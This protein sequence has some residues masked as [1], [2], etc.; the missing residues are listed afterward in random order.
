LSS[1]PTAKEPTL[2]TSP[3]EQ[4][5]TLNTDEQ[6]SKAKATEATTMD[7]PSQTTTASQSSQASNT[8]TA[9]NTSGTTN[10]KSDGTGKPARRRTVNLGLD[11][12][13]W[14]RMSLESS[15]ASAAATAEATAAAAESSRKRRRTA[16]ERLDLSAMNAYSNSANSERS[17]RSSKANNNTSMD[18]DVMQVGSDNELNTSIHSE[19]SASAA[20]KTTS[21]SNKDRFVLFKAKAHLA[22]R[23]ETGS[24][25]LCQACHSIYDDSKKCKIQWLEETAPNTYK[26]DIVDWMDPSAIIAKVNVKRTANNLIEIEQKDLEKVN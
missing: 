5:T 2:T 22:V 15:G 9:A 13:Y 26:Y 18:A 7:N 23:N 1:K 3:Q 8:E 21:P 14:S 24:F 20:N 10:S 4:A 17:S 16:T 19:S 12:G 25:F 6:T 11:G